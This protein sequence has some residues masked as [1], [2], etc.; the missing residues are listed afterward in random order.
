[1]NMDEVD[2]LILAIAAYVAVAALVNLM[3]KRHRSLVAK[4]R[5]ESQEEQQRK[6]A[7]QEKVDGAKGGDDRRAA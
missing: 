6:A 5:R 3:L 4:F 7:E 1:M 2:L